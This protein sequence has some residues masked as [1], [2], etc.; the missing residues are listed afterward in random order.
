[1]ASGGWTVVY[2][3]RPAFAGSDQP[4]FYIFNSSSFCAASVLTTR[5]HR[6]RNDR[7]LR[8]HL[9]CSSIPVEDYAL[10][11]KSSRVLR[12]SRLCLCPEASVD[13]KS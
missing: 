2:A 10:P 7:Q 11:R 1:V 3:W 9:P 5:P 12:A 13:C 4:N 6:T 8:L